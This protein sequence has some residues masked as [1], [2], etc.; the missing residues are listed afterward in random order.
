MNTLQELTALVDVL[1]RD[2]AV[3]VDNDGQLIIF[4]GLTSDDKGAL[5]DFNPDEID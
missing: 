2:G 1:F 4:T 5:S 3:E